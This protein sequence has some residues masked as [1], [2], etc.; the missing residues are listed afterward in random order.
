A[1][2][3]RQRLHLA[4]QGRLASS[5]VTSWPASTSSSAAE[6]PAR[7]P[8]TTTTLIYASS[9]RERGSDHAQLGDRRKRRRPAE[10]F[11][12]VVLDPVERRAI[13][14]G[15]RRDAGG[16]PAVQVIEQGQAFGEVRPR[17]LGLEAHQLEPFGGDEPTS[18]VPLID[19]EPRELGLREVDAPERPVLGAA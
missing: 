7:P 6:S 19:A 5:T 8:P 1:L 10:D 18:D 13:E 15:K 16:A 9:S 3:L 4:A 11:E 2:P 12:S 17:T 14:A